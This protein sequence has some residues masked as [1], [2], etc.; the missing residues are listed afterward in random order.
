MEAARGRLR[1]VTSLAEYGEFAE[2][3]W[4]SVATELADLTERKR[5]LARLTQ[6]GASAHR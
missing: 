1:A 5:A 6:I 4:Q 3:N 2:L